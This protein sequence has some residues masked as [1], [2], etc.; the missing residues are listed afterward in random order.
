[1]N[2]DN[3]RENEGGGRKR[4]GKKVEKKGEGERRYK[5]VQMEKKFMRKMVEHPSVSY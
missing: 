4:S 2:I 5:R 1:M 3:E